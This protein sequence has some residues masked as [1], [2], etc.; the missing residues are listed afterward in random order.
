M[1]RKTNALDVYVEDLDA[2][3][4]SRME[5]QRQLNSLSVNLQVWHVET[6][7]ELRMICSLL[8]PETVVVARIS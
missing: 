2:P 8:G 4:R 5:L 7:P 3:W 6:F 1:W